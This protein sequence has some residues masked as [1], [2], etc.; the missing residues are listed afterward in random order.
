MRNSRGL[1]TGLSQDTW[2]VWGL[3]HFQ[4]C[5]GADSPK[6]A[7]E[8]DPVPRAEHINPFNVVPH[9]GQS[10]HDRAP[11]LKGTHPYSCF[12]GNSMDKSR[13]SP[14]VACW[15]R[16]ENILFTDE[17][18][19]TIE[20]QYNYQNNKVYDQKYQEVPHH[21]VTHLHFCKKGVKLVSE[22]IK[23]MCYKESQNILTWPSSVVSNGSSSRT[24]Y[25]PKRPRQLRSGCGGTFWPSSA[26]R[27]GFRGVQTSNPWTINCGLFWR[28]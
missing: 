7:L 18:I 9:Q 1:K 12:E 14:P 28:T 6:S 11:P 21:G 8:T 10:T 16:A 25:L 3:S 17:K 13:A 20:E 24:Q 27:I 22:C 15:E 4:N 5:A 19:F 26:P 23:R 2:K